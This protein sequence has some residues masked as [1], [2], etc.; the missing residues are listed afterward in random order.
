MRLTAESRELAGLEY[1]LQE[2]EVERLQNTLPVNLL[3]KKLR[4]S[5]FHKIFTSVIY[6]CCKFEDE[7]SYLALLLS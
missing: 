1:N 7:I 6:N 2:K 5:Q 3:L 4:Y